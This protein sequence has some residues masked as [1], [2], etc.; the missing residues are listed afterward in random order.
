MSAF[1]LATVQISVFR[2]KQITFTFNTVKQ[3]RLANVLFIDNPVGAGY[4]YVDSNEYTTDVTQIAIDLVTMWR[5]F[6]VYFP[7]FQVRLWPSWHIDSI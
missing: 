6:L 4:S 3:V 1:S 5:A 2:I 7:E